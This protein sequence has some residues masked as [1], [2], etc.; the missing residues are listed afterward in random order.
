MTMKE[1]SMKKNVVWFHNDYRVD[2]HPAFTAA[3]KTT[4]PLVAVTFFP[5]PTNIHG[6]TIPSNHRAQAIYQALEALHLQL[7]TMGIGYVVVSSIEE[8]SSIIEPHTIESVFYH[9]YPGSSEKAQLTSFQQ[10]YSNCTFVSFESYSLLHPNDL[11]FS[12]D[13]L[14]Q[15]FTSFRK[16]IED[17]VIARPPLPPVKINQEGTLYSLPSI[18]SLGY[19]D[20]LLLVPSD[21]QSALERLQYYCIDSRHVLRYKETRNG[22]FHWDDSSKLSIY[23]SVGSLSPRRVYQVLQEAEQRFGA[24]EST[25][26]LW[27]ELLWRDFFYF[28]HVKEQQQFF[29]PWN[30]PKNLRPEE[31]RL[32]Q[33]IVQGETGYPLIDANMKELVKTGWMS[34]RGRQN[35]AS[36]FVHYCGLPW[37]L[38]ATMFEAYLLDY[39][40]S[41]N[42]GNW[43]Y[44]SGVGNDPRD[45]RIFN[46]VKQG[47]DYDKSTEYI[48]RWLPQLAKLPTASRYHV[49][50]L[51]AKE[52]SDLSYPDPVVGF[53]WT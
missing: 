14:P 32:F 20:A 34:N 33:A 49:H 13:Q 43:R 27:F 31:E 39:N 21:E 10:A 46:V 37:A 28:V 11:P 48:T 44:V 6:L 16:K 24:N 18:K 3:A 52:R 29:Q 47:L 25:Y 26:W 8:L 42:V 4:L 2:D 22:M 50:K 19:E 9:S 40:V 7:S 15:G 35:V 23:L 30:L 36:F 1:Q 17:R 12:L 53:P 45:N 51:S 5:V 41:S 38:G